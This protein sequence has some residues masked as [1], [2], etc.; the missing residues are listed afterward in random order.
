[1]KLVMVAAL[2]TL[3]ERTR[4]SILLAFSLLLVVRQICRKIGDPIG[5]I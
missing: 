2:S 5:F 3:E 4:F 1:M